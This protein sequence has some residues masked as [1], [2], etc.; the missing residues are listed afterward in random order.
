M[1]TPS[2]DQPTPE[3]QQMVGSCE[4]FNIQPFL[5]AANI[6]VAGDEPLRAIQLLD[7][8]PG[9]YRDYVPV[10]AVELKKKI[11]SL[12]A[13]PAFYATNPYDQ[14]VRHETAEQVIQ[15][16][17]RGQLI[18]KD[19]KELNEKNQTPHII[20][21]GP[22][23]YWMAIGLKKL[24]C[25]FT[26]QDIGLCTNARL[27]AREHLLKEMDTQPEKEAPRI[28]IACELI[29]HLHHESDLRVDLERNGG[30]A[31]ILHFS[32]PKYTFD[33]RASQLN[34]A[35]KG[36]LGHLR[37]YTPKEFHSVI[38]KLFPEYAFTM[39]DSQIMHLRGA[40]Q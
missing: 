15:Q 38:T 26:Y 7:N 19:V 25:R 36:D 34:W 20:D 22:G 16:T 24:S 40:L 9:F 28:F 3:Q 13:T 21:L 39:Y 10:A 23:E 18:L 35:L 1:T 30:N 6:L 5:D 2:H 37:T 29:E 31:H 32:T 33:G 8:L 27:L 14:L 12:L 4:F 11:Y 17:L